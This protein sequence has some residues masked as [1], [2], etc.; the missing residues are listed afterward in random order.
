MRAS[1]RELTPRLRLILYAFAALALIA[2]VML[3]AGATRTEDYFSWTIEPPLTAATL[4]AFYWAALVL[5]VAAARSGTWAEARPA[6]YPVTLIAVLLLIVTLIHLDRFD[7]DSLFGWFWLVTYCLIPPVMLWAIVDQLRPPAGD[8]GA[9]NRA[10]AGRRSLRPLLRSAL[11]VE[12]AVM[13]AAGALILVAPETAADLWPWALT[14]LTSRAIGAF[15][16]GI[17]AAALIAVRDDDLELFRGA[18]YAY[19]ALG[20][21]QLLAVLLHEP[22][23]GDDGL[24]SGIYLAFLAAIAA[25]GLY[26]SIAASASSRS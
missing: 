1:M 3:F 2:G 22:D 21:L 12:G 14:P 8:A 20:A 15:V 24:A 16:L 13:L 5:L 6:I 4:G 19:A 25:T 17:G 10:T 23:L 11:A 26:G 18:A 7:L 9:A